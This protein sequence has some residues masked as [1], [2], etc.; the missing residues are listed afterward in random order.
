MSLTRRVTTKVG[1]TTD[2]L[3]HD[4]RTNVDEIVAIVREELLA[5]MAMHPP[6]NSAHEGWAVI[7]EEVDE[8]WIEVC[9]KRNQRDP[10]Q[11]VQEAKQIAAMACRFV[12]D[13]I[14]R[15]KPTS[16]T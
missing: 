12:L 6:L 2:A 3:S 9:K 7:M 10:A 16:A 8:L 14:W 1:T 15:D 5:A 4:D 11:M 13:V